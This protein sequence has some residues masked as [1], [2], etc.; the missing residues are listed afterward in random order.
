VSYVAE[1]LIGGTG[2]HHEQPERR[3]AHGGVQQRGYVRVVRGEVL[4]LDE[5]VLAS[6]T[7]RL[8]DRVGDGRLAPW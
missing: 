4:I 5:D 8:H 3:L 2:H 1:H 7:D 6:R